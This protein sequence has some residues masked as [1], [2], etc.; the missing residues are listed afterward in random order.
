VQFGK[1]IDHRFIDLP[2]FSG[3]EIG[4]SLYPKNA[5]IDKVHDVKIGADD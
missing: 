5:T 1:G 2:P 4:Q 3:S